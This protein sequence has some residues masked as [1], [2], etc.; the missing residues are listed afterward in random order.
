MPSIEPY[1]GSYTIESYE[2]QK[3]PLLGLMKKGEKL[4]IA[5]DGR[6]GATL[7]WGD[8]PN[9]LSLPWISQDGGVLFSAPAQLTEHGTLEVPL[10]S[11]GAGMPHPGEVAGELQLPAGVAYRFKAAKA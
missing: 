8:L 5:P 7:S 1:F 2:P 9:S 10:K 4:T 3:G 6:G 11:A